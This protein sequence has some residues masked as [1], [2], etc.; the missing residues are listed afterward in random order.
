MQRLLPFFLLVACGFEDPRSPTLSEQTKLDIL[1]AAQQTANWVPF[2]DYYPSKLDCNDGD[3]MS[4][5]IGYLAAVGYKPSIRAVTESI[6]DGR[7]SRS[8][9]RS[10]TEDAFSRDQMLG[11]M[12]AQLSGENGWLE[13]KRTTLEVGNLCSPSTDTRCTLTPTIYGLMNDVHTFLGYPPSPEL[14]WKEIFWDSLLLT[15]SGTV[16]LGYQL[17]LVANAAW[18]AYKTGN[19]TRATYLAAKNAYLRQQ[20]NPWFCVVHMGPTEECAQKALAIWP[21]ET[22]RKSQWSFERDTAEFAINDSM[23]WEF[24][25]LA[26]LFGVDPNLLD[27]GGKRHLKDD[28]SLL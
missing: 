7:V 25:F 11:F 13:V 12:A 22:E 9:N 24:I 1:F 23:G 21:Q 4:Q 20:D 16:P 28:G 18:I 17:N 2:C 15:Q 19:E 10:D 3:S 27:Y 8:P 26:G 6:K 14:W 5:G